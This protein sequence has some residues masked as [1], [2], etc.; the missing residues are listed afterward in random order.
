MKSYLAIIKARFFCLLQYRAAAL[1]GLFTQIFWGLI[2]TMIFAAFY[3]EGQKEAP[4][5]LETA[6]AFVWINQALLQLLPWNFDKEVM[7]EIR[8]GNV[9]Y[10]L[11]RPIELYWM[12]FCRAIA[13][14]IVPTLLRC[15]PLFILALL[16]FD[17]APPASF[18][19]GALFVLSCLS[20]VLLSAA[21]TTLVML[22]LFWTISGEG[23]VRLMPHIVIL[24][25]GLIIPLPFCPDWAQPFLQAQPFRG[26]TD[27][28][29]RIYTGMIPTCDWPFAIGFQLAWTALFI[30][31][32]R[33]LTKRALSALVIQGG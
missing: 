17:L 5:P 31:F 2:Y 23:I 15:I 20:A 16:F 28:P 12:W 13:M 32:G 1:A 9:A 29:C 14:R 22:S 18:E 19:A 30:L 8:T 21:I 27:I 3:R 10:S 6:C 24:F 25:S 26:I 4:I 11:I 7:Q 33:F